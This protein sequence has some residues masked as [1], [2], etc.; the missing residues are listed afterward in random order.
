MQLESSFNNIQPPL[1]DL[2]T[3][4]LTRLLFDCWLIGGLPEA[5][6]SRGASLNDIRRELRRRESLG[7][8]VPR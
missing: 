4:G 2:S 5:L 1:G 8:G 7:V 6:T 3:K